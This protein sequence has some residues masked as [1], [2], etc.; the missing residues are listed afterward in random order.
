M[1]ANAIVPDWFRI[2]KYMNAGEL[3]EFTK[4]LKKEKC[5]LSHLSHSYA[6]FIWAGIL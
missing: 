1:I 4:Q 3:I 5:I 2:I 6:L